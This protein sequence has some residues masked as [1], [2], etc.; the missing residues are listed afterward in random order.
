[1]VGEVTV[2]WFGNPLC[3]Q[4]SDFPG[5]TPIPGT[6]G[7]CVTD[8]NGN[9]TI[10]NIPYGKYE[11]RAIPPEPNNDYWVQTLTIEGTQGIDAWLEEGTDGRGAIREFLIEPGLPTAYLF[12]FVGP[13]TFGDPSDTC[14]FNDDMTGGTGTLIGTA[15]NWVVFPP[16][17]QL[18][19][20]EPVYRPWIVL[21]DI[22]NSDTMVHRTRGNP[23]GSFVINNVPAGTYQMV[24]WDEPLDYIIQFRTVVVGDG[25]VVNMGDVGVF[26]WFGWV[27]GHVFLDDG[28]D[29]TGAFIGGPE[30]AG[31]AIRDCANPAD[32][33]TC[34]RGLSNTDLLLRFRDG[35][36]QTGTFTDV[37]G[38]YEFPEARGPLGKFQVAEVGFGRFGISGHSKHDEHFANIGP[39][40]ADNVT[41]V[42]GDLGGDL[43]LNQLTWEGKRSIID[44]GKRI[45]DLNAD[46]NGGI[47]GAVLYAVTRN[48]FNASLALAEDYEPGIPGVTVQL[49]GA[50]P[51]EI[52]NTPEE[53][54]F[55]DVLLYEVQTDGWEHPSSANGN[56]CDVKDSFGGF[57]TGLIYDLVSDRCLE[58]PMVANETQDGAWDGGWAI[59]V[60]CPNGWPCDESE[61]VP[62]PSGDYIVQV[63]PPPFYQILKEEDQNTDEGDDLIPQVPPP[64]CVGDL[65]LVMDDRNPY[66]GTMMPLC[67]KKFV[68]VQTGQN[69]AAD[70][71]LFT[72]DQAYVTQVDPESERTSWNTSESVPVPGRFF[73]LVEDDI[74]LNTDPNSLTYGEKRGVPYLPVGI[75]DYQFRLITTIY[76]DENGFYEVLLPSTYTA[77][78]PIPSGICPGMYIIIP[79]DPNSPDFSGAYIVDPVARDIWPGKMT[80]ADTPVDPINTLVCT[81]ALDT[82]QIFRT[83]HVTADNTLSVSLTITG[84]RFGTDP[85]IAPRVTLD[86]DDGVSDAFDLTVTSWVPASVDINNPGD[87][88]NVF[89]D[90]VT[91]TVPAG[92]AGGPYQLSVI[93]GPVHVELDTGPF[94]GG[95]KPSLNGLTLHVLGADY[96]PP[97]ITVFPPASLADTPIQTAINAATPGSLVI[98]SPGTY[99]ENVIMHKGVKLQ[100]FG[101]GG[102]VGAPPAVTPDPPPEPPDPFDPP[103]T[104]PGEEPY[105]HIQGSV[106][107]GRFYTFDADRRADWDATLAGPASPYSGPSEVRPGAGI[108][109]VAQDGEFVIDPKFGA[110]IDGF[111][112]T[113]SRGEAGGAIYVH[114][115]GRGLRISNNI[116]EANQGRHGGAVSVGQPSFFGGL[117]DNENDNIVIRHNRIL[118]NGGVFLAG[119]VGIFNGADN[120]E[121]ANNDVCGNFSLEYGGGISHFGRSPNGSIHD[122]LIYFNS[123]FDEGG[124]IMV[125]GE[126]PA[127]FGGIGSGDVTIAY[128]NIEFEPV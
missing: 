19:F 17:E 90:V 93:S 2:D 40:F 94:D 76:T 20:G 78:C 29:S 24:I 34:E 105:A 23:D 4:Y 116:L 21:T 32:P 47:S 86:D 125:A 50:G 107:D 100:G 68:T 95:G 42:P 89:E 41:V 79:N 120:Y 60:I 6:G 38:F 126:L 74:N 118:S 101:P 102:A 61:E 59:D 99:H 84:T 111:G 25:E 33:A 73:G 113:A 30:L 26:R 91:A 44:W 43:L 46:E 13:C 85:L 1:M 35:S 88:A 123:A 62:M 37:N 110:S 22:G 119:G 56:P 115:Y 127:G 49:W 16:F 63:V 57:L 71:F 108:T 122:N 77:L 58:V 103:T 104:V 112:I 5:G 14:A 51:D 75:Y 36:V 87:P 67:D 48:E 83:S 7:Q 52:L 66:N 11:M 109:V 124:G 117:L 69:P 98:V 9:V 96:S 8:A 72:T 80:P 114:A 121:F 81:V 12:G 39:P 10:D 27:S 54:S 55:D 64:P 31:N 97:I 15:K 128:N 70:F 53:P 65:H 3:T 106:I 45:Y 18:T 28:R 92:L 82:P